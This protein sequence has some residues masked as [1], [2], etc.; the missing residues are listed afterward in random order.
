ML[1]KNILDYFGELSNLTAYFGCK[2]VRMIIKKSELLK[3]E[4]KTCVVKLPAVIKTLN[5]ND[6]CSVSFLKTNE[7]LKALTLDID[8][9]ISYLRSSSFVIKGNVTSINKNIITLNIK[10]FLTDEE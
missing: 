4:G 8:M 1:K 7:N 10:Q 9:G 5:E 2:N 3:I 6:V